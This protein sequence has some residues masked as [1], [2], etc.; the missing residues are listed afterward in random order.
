[1]AGAIVG[2]KRGEWGEAMRILRSMLMALAVLWS[3]AAA[4][5][6]ADDAVELRIMIFNVWLGGEQVNIER[7]FDAIGAADADI[8]LLQEPEGQTR[9]FA[10]A[11]GYAYASER[12]HIISRYPLFDPPTSD[13]DFAF[14]EIRPGRFVAVADIH[15]TS[16]PYG[17]YAVR[18]GKSADEVL[19]LEQDTRMPDIAPYIAALPPLAATGVP[20]FI[21]GDFNAP[22]HLDWT[23][24][25]V[26]ARPALRFPLEWP[27]SK[28]LAD[29]GFRDSYRET[30]PDPVANPG[31][32][33]T[34]GYPVPHRDANEMIDRIDQI[35]ALGNATT[36]ASKIVGESGGPD[37]DIGITP[38]PSDH[39]AVVS[40][41][42]AVP[43]PAPAMVSLDRRAVTAGAPLLVRFH[44]ADSEDGRIEGGK[45][46]IVAA[47]G[48]AAK[49][50]M[51]APTNDGTDRRSVMTFGSVLLKPGAY[52]A[53][54]LNADG[55]ELARAPFWI[56]APGAAPTVSVDHPSYGDTEK[57]VASWKNAPGNRRDWLGIYKAGDPDQMNYIAFVYTNAAIEGTVTFDDSVIGKALEAGD[58]EMR[59]MQDDAY[60]VLATTPFSVSQ[61][62]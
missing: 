28:A 45:V 43:G 58:Y 46:A 34:S 31:I 12:R 51:S 3:L 36:V 25:A 30:H 18:D 26:A 15:L 4:P 55:K 9:R 62:P 10:R 40:T 27:V 16:D 21:G 53:A 50:L 13:A 56:E 41:F 48:D 6:R 39:H 33:W 59:L 17:P 38:W 1:M 5:A 22:S 44:A 47:G 60:L 49:P 7:V 24:A 20:V 11:L 52:D 35:Y 54:L 2:V 8:V 42:K 57:I 29:A 19:K 23:A 61:S 32:T 37:I 14:A